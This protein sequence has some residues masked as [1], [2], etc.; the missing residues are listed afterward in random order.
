MPEVSSE[1][2]V[3]HAPVRAVI[4]EDSKRI[5]EL[6]ALNVKRYFSGR[7]HIVGEGVDVEN[8]VLL[9][10]NL[11]PQLLFLD[12]ELM[13]GTGFDILDILA[14]EREEM[15]IVVISTH[16]KYLKQAVS[17]GIVDFISKPI[18]AAEFQRSLEQCIK[19]IHARQAADVRLL[20]NA[21]ARWEANPYQDTRSLLA[22][23]VQGHRAVITIRHAGVKEKT[24]E[25]VI[26]EITHCQAE[27]GYTHIY[28]ENKSFP[29]TDS[30]PLARYEEKLTEYG[31]LRI[32][33]SLLINP[34]HCRL[35]QEGKDDI[36]AILPNG[37]A[38]PVEGM[39][40]EPILAYLRR[41]KE[42]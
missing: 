41:F 14:D 6:V 27:G 22:K 21:R 30:K 1:P 31:F 11:R 17:Y 23:A 15:S 7:I 18:L 34:E 24:E 3:F 25:I 8:S 32:S 2:A 10:R 38:H 26:H 19:K 29:V 36:T 39:H 33:R 20:E 37:T 42:K 28:Q 16:E 9:I 35:L 40:K 5:R 12:I 4:V 13:R